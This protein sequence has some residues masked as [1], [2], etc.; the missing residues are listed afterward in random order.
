MIK[1]VLLSLLL[2]STVPS[3]SASPCSPLTRSEIEKVYGEGK[4]YQ[5]D[6]NRPTQGGCFVECRGE[7]N[8]VEGL[9][10]RYEPQRNNRGKLVFP[11]VT[12]DPNG[13]VLKLSL[14][15]NDGWG[16]L[17]DE[18]A[19]VLPVRRRGD[20]ESMKEKPTPAACCYWRDEKYGCVEIHIWVDHT[21]GAAPASLDV[22]W[23]A[24]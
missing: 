4:V 7:F 20:E 12:Y 3:D 6:P 16:P 10:V 23:R 8:D 21:K 11:F 15:G 17:A 2:S 1:A 24:R 18:L 13:V 14:I 22:R 5:P 9:M 19:V